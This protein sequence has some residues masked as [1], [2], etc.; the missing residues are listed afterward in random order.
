MLIV[1]GS[2]RGLAPSLFEGGMKS[3]QFALDSGPQPIPQ[4]KLSNSPR[5][6]PAMSLSPVS[7]DR[8]VVDHPM[9]ETYQAH[10]TTRQLFRIIKDLL[11]R[12]Y[13]DVE[14]AFHEM[15]DINTRRLSQEQLFQLLKMYIHTCLYIF[16]HLEH[17]LFICITYVNS[18]CIRI[19]SILHPGHIL[20][21]VHCLRLDDHSV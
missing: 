7:V 13:Q 1:F 12:R 9:E 10:R 4:P 2:D 16:I 21:P 20:L 5:Q 14:R 6:A 15:D 8:L 18:V 11:H 19:S 3:H 17:R